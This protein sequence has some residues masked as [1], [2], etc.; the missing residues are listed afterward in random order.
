MK[1]LSALLTPFE[2]NPKVNGGFCLYN[3][4]IM[5]SFHSLSLLQCTTN[6]WVTC[7]IRCQ[8]N[9]VTS[10]QWFCKVF[11]MRCP[12]VC[13]L[14]F[15]YLEKTMHILW[16]IAP[17]ETIWNNTSN[18]ARIDGFHQA[19]YLYQMLYIYIYKHMNK[20]TFLHVWSSR[21]SFES[22]LLSLHKF[23]NESQDSNDYFWEPQ[24]CVC[25]LVI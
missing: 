22:K 19:D 7:D 23:I 8:D 16:L 9:H 12:R 20:V 14:A 25:C 17:A 5:S 4:L 21:F 2:E 10:L 6:S 3:R 24:F 13:E 11:L 18:Q 15:K 1:T